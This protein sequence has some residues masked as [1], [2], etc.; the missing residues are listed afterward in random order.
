[1][2]AML[3]MTA[4]ASSVG[5]LQYPSL[6]CFT[7]R[8][9]I[10]GALS[11]IAGM[12]PCFAEES[13][14][15]GTYSKVGSE[16]PGNNN[17]F[18]MA[19]Y[20]YCPRILRAWIAVDELGLQALKERDWEGVQIVQARMLD[21]TTA[22]PLF[23]SSVEGARSTKR[24]KKSDTQKSMA[25]ETERFKNSCIELQAAIDGKDEQ[26]AT[27][28]LASAREA[29]GEYRRLGKIDDPDG[30]MVVPENTAEGRGGVPDAQYVGFLVPVFTGGGAM[31]SKDFRK[32][33]D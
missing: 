26:R 15:G 5:A 2:S 6:R 4:I 24:K 29:L 25:A 21:A 30:G 18:P 10:A 13:S 23:T 11:A 31:T 22:M 12:P 1:M 9:M 7:R 20:R 28:A 33:R 8:H 14:S 17:Y 27:T 16:R 19:R 3:A 32:L